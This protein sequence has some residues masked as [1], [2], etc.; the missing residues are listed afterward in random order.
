MYTNLIY[1]KNMTL[2]KKSNNN[3]CTAFTEYYN[4]VKIPRDERAKEIKRYT[5][6]YTGILQGYQYWDMSIPPELYTNSM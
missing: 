2:S 6:L 3:I 1:I 4:Y 5:K